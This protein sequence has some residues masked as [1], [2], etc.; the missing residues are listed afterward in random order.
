MTAVERLPAT[1]TA[2][3]TQAPRRARKRRVWLLDIAAIAV[4]AVIGISLALGAWEAWVALKDIKPFIVP[5]PH[6][7]AQRLAEDPA[8]FARGLQDAA[9]AMIGFSWGTAVAAAGDAHSA[10]E[11]ART[12]PVPAGHPRKGDADRGDRRC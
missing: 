3:A 11:G 4:P 9:S 12:R 5:A 6:V 10:V 2:A 7:V 8:L 1:Q